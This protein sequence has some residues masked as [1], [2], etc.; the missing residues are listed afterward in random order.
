MTVL[1]LRAPSY[2]VYSIW[3][4]EEIGIHDYIGKCY[5]MTGQR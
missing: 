5:A 3:R 2:V 1:K 4:D